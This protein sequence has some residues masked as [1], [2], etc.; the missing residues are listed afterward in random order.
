MMT[1][2]EFM[3]ACMQACGCLHKDNWLE[4]F[5]HCLGTVRE[6]GV[7]RSGPLP[8]YI[9]KYSY[10]NRCV[11]VMPGSSHDLETIS[12]S[13][14]WSYTYSSLLS[15]THPF[16]FFQQT[17]SLLL[18]SPFWLPLPCTLFIQYFLLQLE[19]DLLFSLTFAPLIGCTVASSKC[20]SNRLIPG[21]VARTTS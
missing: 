8:E 3:Q 20:Y 14:L 4:G 17:P 13:M 18:F 19:T 2:Q 9:V 7:T 15:S 10:S 12:T 6:I 11:T 1:V 21:S 16:I 5:S